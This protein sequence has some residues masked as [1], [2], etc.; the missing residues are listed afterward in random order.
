[1][2]SRSVRYLFDDLLS[3][4]EALEI[5]LL[6]ARSTT[7]K[8]RFGGLTAS[9]VLQSG[10]LLEGELDVIQAKLDRV[11]GAISFTE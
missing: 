1:M 10:L 6:D 5:V 7:V 2:A 4:A 3:A 11:S 8:Y 9:Q